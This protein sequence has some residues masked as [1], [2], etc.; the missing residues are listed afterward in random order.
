MT[1]I[2][3][4]KKLSGKEKKSLP[5]QRYVNYVL[6]FC[7]HSSTGFT[8]NFCSLAEVQMYLL[9]ISFVLQ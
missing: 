7:M 8:P 6:Q 9:M 3:L 4:F 5:S 1:L 2:N